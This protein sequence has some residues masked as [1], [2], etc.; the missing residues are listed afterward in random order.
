GEVV[1]TRGRRKVRI[2]T[3]VNAHLILMEALRQLDLQAADLDTAG[4]RIYKVGLSFPLEMTRIDTFV[5]G[6]AEVL[7]I[8]EKGPV[9][10]Q[11][12]K[13]HLYNRAPGARP[14]VLGKHDA[15]GAPL[16]SELGE[17]RP[18]RLL[19]VFAEWPARHNPALDPRARVVL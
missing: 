13:D 4:V 15:A 9:I 12:I 10:E 1:G 2:V 7:V 8:E 16:L 5:E 3:C 19:P 18:S 17:L 14:V 6:L 11:Q